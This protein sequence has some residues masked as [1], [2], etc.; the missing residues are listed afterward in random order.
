MATRKPRTPSAVGPDDL[1]RYAN[2]IATASTPQAAVRLLL[3]A[4]QRDGWRPPDRRPDGELAWLQPA[5]A[6]RLIHPP[7]KTGVSIAT[8]HAYLERG[9]LR[10][11][12]TA[13][14]D[15]HIDPT[16]IGQLNEVFAMPQ[17]SGK[18][19]SRYYSALDTLVK[20]NRGQA[21]EGETPTGE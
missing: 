10:G 16:S 5:Q 15:R 3:D 20:R 1:A 19:R 12:Q 4:L 6:R 2:L 18:E 9:W 7:G 21:G 8:V 17:T 14:G 13:R 11:R